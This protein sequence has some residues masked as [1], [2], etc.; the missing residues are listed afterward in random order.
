METLL[1]CTG[2]SKRFERNVVP[3][4]GFQERLFGI[5]GARK[6]RR[7]KKNAVQDVSLSLA[8]GEWLGI[9]GPNG[10]GKTTLLKML[11]GL[12]D[13][14]EGT[15]EHHCAISSFFGL[16][17]GFNP[18][19]SAEENIYHHALLYGMHRRDILDVMEEV[20]AFAEVE[21]HRDLPIK[22]YSQG[23]QARLAFAAAMH[24]TAEL[25][26]LDEVLAVGDAAFNIK[27]MEQM[28]RHKREGKSAILVLHSL[29]HLRQNCDRILHMEN[30]RIVREEIV[31]TM[32]SADL[33]QN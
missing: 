20:I 14:D 9:Y 27:C 3:H 5:G 30:G 6:A 13:P 11:G 32:V 10:S 26:L 15:I 33:P 19:R 23:M 28:S 4:I 25:F 12:I 2:I 24:V 22:C 18:D 8:P 7:W 17:V 31:E 1:Q 21:S 29:G 16:G